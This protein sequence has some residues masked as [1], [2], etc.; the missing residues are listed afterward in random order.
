[1]A[2]TGRAGL[3]ALALTIA[4]LVASQPAAVLGI[5]DG[6]LL[7]VILLDVALATTT[8]QL[9]ITRSLPPGGRL[10]EPL[11]A[12]LIVSN[13]GTRTVRALI[14]DAWPPSA[15]LRPPSADVRIPGGER[16]RLPQQFLPSRRGDRT[17]VSVTIRSYG[18]LHLGARQ[19]NVAAPGR[20]RVQPAFPSRKLLPEKL[21]RLR[22]IEGL[23]ATRGPG[24][25]TEFDSLREYVRGDD[26][27]A[28]DW[29]AS[30]RRGATI[31]GSAGTG[32]S[33]QVRQYRPERDRRLIV[34]LDTGR[35]S[36]ARVGDAPRLDASLDAALLLAAVALRAGD[37]IDLLAADAVPRALLE[38][39]TLASLSDAMCG[40]E[41][42]L[43]EADAG[44]IVGQV[45][46][47]ARR[48]CL[49]VLFTDL[50]AAAVEEGLL[51]ALTPLLRRH[52]LLVAAVADPRVAELALG[53]G[54]AEAVYG[55]AAAERS[56]AERRR[57][58]ALLRRR[59]VE[60]VDVAPEHFA[61]A[62][63][64]RY[65]ALKAAGRL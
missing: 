46:R 50:T 21:S 36:A 40:L 16:R 48:R 25:G 37:R 63:S 32:S 19:R 8:R 6:V 55:A 53:R 35:T 45:L 22:I 38:R 41:P 56:L 20:I 5:A 18:P 11:D 65:L 30:A 52:E 7:L 42:V 39:A 62:V 28:I 3:I 60:V 34:V 29:R 15:G 12:S 51:P 47:L 57:L 49:V 17:G 58:A 10:G 4:V 26:V 33:L 2:V 9:A 59:G 44:A 1:M 27:R 14:R 54:S 64:D 61:S 24:R 23:V 43:V 13:T 31:G